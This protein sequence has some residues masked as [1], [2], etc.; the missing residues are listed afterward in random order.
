MDKTP[1]YILLIDGEV[2][3][4]S[5]GRLWSQRKLNEWVS[6]YCQSFSVGGSNWLARKKLNKPIRLPN[7]ITIATNTPHRQIVRQWSAPAFMVL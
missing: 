7:T 4:V 2:S 3:N 1:K 5:I 6:D